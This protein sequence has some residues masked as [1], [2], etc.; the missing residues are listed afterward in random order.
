[1]RRGES[2]GQSD[3]HPCRELNHKCQKDRVSEVVKGNPVVPEEAK[4]VHIIT[5][6]S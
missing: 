5:L 2:S 6:D 3:W 4:S 1:M